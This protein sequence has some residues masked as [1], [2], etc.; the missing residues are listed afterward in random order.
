MYVL[1]AVCSTSL[2]EPMK[3]ILTVDEVKTI[4]LRQ[5]NQEFATDFNEV[6]FGGY[7]IFTDATFE[8]VE[9]QINEVQ[10]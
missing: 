2:K 8:V 10:S 6:T 7:S 9:P 3:L 4:L 5:I 1:R